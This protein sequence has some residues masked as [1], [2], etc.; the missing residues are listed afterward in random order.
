MV[1]E[2][3]EAIAKRQVVGRNRDGRSTYDPQARSDLVRVSRQPSVSL[4][5]FARER[6]WSTRPRTGPRRDSSANASFMTPRPRCRCTDAATQKDEYPVL[7]VCFMSSRRPWSAPR[8]Q[9]RR[10]ARS[11]RRHRYPTMRGLDL[12]RAGHE[13]DGQSAV[14][15]GTTLQGA[16][17][18][19]SHRQ[20]CHRA[21]GGSQSTGRSIDCTR[22]CERSCTW[23]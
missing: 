3:I 17:T 18:P 12:D 13:S 10:E 9:L 19:S 23:N 8:R 21:G 14:G 16:A 4:A 1:T 15:L 6:G 20:H 11:R 5:R 7:I 2:D 22:E